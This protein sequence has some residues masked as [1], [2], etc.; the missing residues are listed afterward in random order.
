MFMHLFLLFGLFIN[1]KS[2][3]MF[4]MANTYCYLLFTSNKLQVLV[5]TLSIQSTS[6]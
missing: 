6:I 5:N 3:I 4:K 2:K 1:P